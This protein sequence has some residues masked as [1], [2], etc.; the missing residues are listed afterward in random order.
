MTFRYGVVGCG[1]MGRNHLKVL[2]HA[3]GVELVGVYDQALDVACTVA[4]ELGTHAFPDLADLLV[5]VDG[6]SIVTPTETH[7][8]LAIAAL[9]ADRHVLVEK[10]IAA[11]L[12][13]ARAIADAARKSGR[14]VAVGHLE[15]F[16]PAY[17]ALRQR[18]EAVR[19]NLVV[20]RRAGPGPN[21]RRATGA[22][23][24]LGIHDLDL[25][26][27]L[28]GPPDFASGH[29][30]PEGAEIDLHSV[31]T[32]RFGEIVALVESS[33]RYEAHTRTVT[34]Y[35]PTGALV[36]DLRNKT[37][38]ADGHP[39]TTLGDAN[40]LHEEI[41]DF[42]SAATSGGRPR[43]VIEDALH[44]LEIVEGILRG[45]SEPR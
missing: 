21:R 42:V 14:T 13:G 38:T 40:Q 28:F 2:K 5:R 11:D 19:P 29:R 43:V 45:D 8:A 20:A 27:D 24:E 39:P 37:I 23:V 36:A 33:R 44:S 1:D 32:L 17:L 30:F 12:R 3:A 26:V 7:E 4:G 9:H 35:L 41:E 18:L 34:A 25:L 6:L 10:P 15:R 31:V 22:L 16:N